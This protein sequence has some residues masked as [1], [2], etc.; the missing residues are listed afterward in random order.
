MLVLVDT[1]ILVYAFD[2]TQGEK[3]HSA[4]KICRGLLELDR[5]CL[6]TQILQE[7]YVTLTRKAS[8][9]VETALAVLDDLSQWP[10]FLVDYR[11]IRD[12]AIIARDN[13]IA[14]WDALLIAAAATLGADAL[15]TEDLNHGQII[16]GVEI[17]N[18][19]K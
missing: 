10:V 12:A 4:I 15:L 17:R 9:P 5:I 2:P 16:A 3:H 8:L 19:F 14:F 1:N 7:L 18:P 13:R 11:A 6:S